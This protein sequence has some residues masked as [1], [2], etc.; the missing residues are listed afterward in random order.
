M[1]KDERNSEEIDIRRRGIGER[2]GGQRGDA[3][4]RERVGWTDSLVFVEART[5]G[6]NINRKTQHPAG[7]ATEAAVREV[8][9][10]ESKSESE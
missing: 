7:A 2:G 10:G 3:K 4:G 1:R 9:E 6:H 8:K 5:H